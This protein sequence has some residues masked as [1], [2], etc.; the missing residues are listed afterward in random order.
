[1]D[2]VIGSFSKMIRNGVKSEKA[3]IMTET[4]ALM[5]VKTFNIEKYVDEA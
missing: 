5:N 1:M 2:D 3:E 4:G